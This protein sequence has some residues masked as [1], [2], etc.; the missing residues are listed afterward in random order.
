V[1][2]VKDIS[3]I[4]MMKMLRFLKLAK[5]VKGAK[6]L[7]DMDQDL[8]DLIQDFLAH[9]GT[10]TVLR[11]SNIL[12]KMFFL[13][14]IMAC[15][16]VA[17]GRAGVE[18]GMDSWF[19]HDFEEY[20]AKD[21][22]RGNSV[23]RIYLSAFY[24]CLTTMTTVG[25]GDT[26]PRNDSERGMAICLEVMGGLFYAYIVGSLTALITQ[27][28]PNSQKM[29]EVLGSVSSYIDKVDLPPDLGRR[30]RRFYRYQFDKRTAVNESEILEGLTVGL[31]N[32]VAQFLVHGD[33]KGGDTMVFRLMHEGLWARFI[34]LLRP[35]VFDHEEIVCLQGDY[36]VEALLVKEGVF[37]ASTDLHK[38]EWLQASGVELNVAASDEGSVGREAAEFQER[39]LRLEEKEFANKL[40]LGRFIEKSNSFKETTASSLSLPDGGKAP[41]F[42]RR[43]P[44]SFGGSKTTPA[45]ET[46]PAAATS[47]PAYHLPVPFFPAN[48]GGG[49]GGSA[50]AA[51]GDGAGS[52]SQSSFRNM[53]ASIKDMTGARGYGFSNAFVLEVGHSAMSFGGG[54][55]GGGFGG[56]GG[57]N[58]SPKQPTTTCPPVVVG[59]SDD[60]S[61]GVPMSPLR[62]EHEMLHRVASMHAVLRPQ[63]TKDAL[64]IRLSELSQAP[65]HELLDPDLLDESE[66]TGAPL[67]SL[68]TSQRLGQPLATIERV[69]PLDSTHSSWSSSGDNSGSGFGQPLDA[70]DR[71]SPVDG[72][73]SSWSNSRPNSGS[74]EETKSV[75]QETPDKRS[76]AEEAA[77]AAFASMMHASK[78]KLPKLSFKEKITDNG[79]LY[80]R[81]VTNGQVVNTLGLYRL[82]PRC[83]ESVKA[84]GPVECHAVSTRAFAE[85][86]IS[87]S[88]SSSSGS[89]SGSCSGYGS[90]GHANDN[91]DGDMSVFQAMQERVATT[92]FEMMP[93]PGG[94]LFGGGAASTT[95]KWGVPVHRLAPPEIRAR[96][97]EYFKKQERKLKERH[98]AVLEFH[99]KKSAQRNFMDQQL[100]PATPLGKK[101]SSSYSTSSNRSSSSGGS[102]GIGG[103][104][105][106]TF[107]R[108]SVG[109]KD[110]SS[111]SKSSNSSSSSSSSSSVG[112][113]GGDSKKTFVRASAVPATEAEKLE[114]RED[115]ASSKEAA[116]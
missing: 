81:V 68:S 26:H 17:V 10:K 49:G 108:A 110:S 61:S 42:L 51:S 41:P 27:G 91:D 63:E 104:S 58:S 59:P 23:A 78:K 73:R 22:T 82:W 5:L 7:N 33:L 53:T 34:P 72:S 87:S 107:V 48:D 105:K 37:T 115:T 80:M 36:C 85:L 43:R 50:G 86:F 102:S 66:S 92:Q 32:E 19:N 109:K 97:K 4:R 65:L 20:E 13:V 106:R 60:S 93:D 8:V 64:H 3:V 40:K 30:I 100:N 111:N 55:F 98:Q 46:A 88:S 1:Q 11:I 116:I 114:R 12:G 77:A 25:F 29:E 83:L 103:D 94:L 9:K 67:S 70:I 2:L 79:T 84:A 52:G 90:S 113:S 35:C 38:R 76:A 62:E 69:S 24:F 112:S 54:S 14:H 96:E 21:T 47:G 99:R 18:A 31:R 74:G 45:A 39:L 75:E 101:D 89:G 95:S 57:S 44:S 71:A 15:L 6:V 56:E 28:D 16:W